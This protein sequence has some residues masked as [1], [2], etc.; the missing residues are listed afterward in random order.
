M[1]W[2]FADF[3]DFSEKYKYLENLTM[4]EYYHGQNTTR[5]GGAFHQ[6][7]LLQIRFEMLC[8]S[9]PVHR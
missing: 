7:F 3:P 9:G 4:D 5:K 6:P 8:G 2:G 1:V